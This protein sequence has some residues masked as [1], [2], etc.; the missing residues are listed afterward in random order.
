MSE[1]QVLSVGSAVPDFELET[2]LPEDRAFG[3]V[4]LAE[5][6]RQ[7]KWTILVFYPADFTFVCPTELADLADQYEALGKLGAEV[8]SVSTDTKYAHMAWRDHEKLLQNVKYPMGADSNGR[9]SRMFGVYDPE[10]G[11][12]LRGTFIIN[13]LGVLVSS[14][15]TYYNV[16]RNAQELVR[17]LEANVYLMQHPSEACPANWKKGSKTLKPSGEIVGKVYEALQG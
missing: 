2:Y 12:S 15:V 6:R 13:P 1:V 14:E 9:L 7:N 11:L 10:S 8:V 5:L 4:S 17:K 16:G 3:K